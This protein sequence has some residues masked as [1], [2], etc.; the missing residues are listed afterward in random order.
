MSETTPD[1]PKVVS[2]FTLTA[3]QMVQA[4]MQPVHAHPEANKVEHPLMGL[5]TWDPERI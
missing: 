2:E 4:W 5:Q 1:R 3:F